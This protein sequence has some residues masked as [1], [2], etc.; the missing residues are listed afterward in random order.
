MT[1][2][3]TLNIHLIDENDNVPVLD[4]NALVMCLSDESPS[5]SISAHDLD[6]VPYSEP[7]HFELLGD[8]KGKWTIDPKQGT[9][10]QYVRP[11]FL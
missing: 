5:T 11:L 1:G 2:T 4:A 8:E 10:S 6:Q 3:G 9:N 7:F